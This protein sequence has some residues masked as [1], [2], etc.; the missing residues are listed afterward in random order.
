MGDR[1]VAVR[2][3][4][5]VQGF[6][7][8]LT[9]AAT[10]TEAFGAKLQGA[11]PHV[12]GLV[13]QMATG[14]VGAV[15]LAAAFSAPVKA[16][17][18]FDQ[19]VSRVKSTG[20]VTGAQLE[21]LKTQAM[22]MAGTFGVSGTQAM[23]AVEALAKAGVS[24]SDILGGGLQG[25]L[26][27]AAA[28][29]MDVGQAAETASSAMT[30]FGLSGKDVGHVADVLSNGANMAQ[31][32]VKDL[33]MALSQGG[34]VASQMG[35]SLD[36]TVGALAEFA[37]AGLMGS[38]AGTSLK[39]MLQKLAAPSTQA[40]QVMS[41]LGIHVYDAQ[42]HFVGLDGIAGQLR[43]SM[44]HLSESQRNAAL[45][46]IFGSDAV[47]AASIL[48]KDGANTAADWAKN[49]GK[50][51]AAMQ[52]AT[53][54]QDN[55]AGSLA[56]L[57]ASWTNAF[58]T[59]GES[60]QGPLKS[61]VDK[62][63]AL[64][65]VVQRNAGAAQ[66]IAGVAAALIGLGAAAVG[67]AKVVSAIRAAKTAF[68]AV[69]SAVVTA[70]QSFSALAS[71]AEQSGT[72]TGRALSK[73]GGIKGAAA[74]ATGGV[75]ALGAAM[76]GAQQ[77]VD[78]FALS[79][80]QASAALNGL[81]SGSAQKVAS[82]MDQIN[83]SFKWSADGV[84]DLS[85][86]LKYLNDGSTWHRISDGF[87]Q[88]S[89]GIMGTK[90]NAETL[91]ERF[92]A[93]DEQLAKMRP[94]QRAAAWHQLDAELRRNGTGTSEMI[95][96]MPRLHAMLEEQARSLGVTSLSAKDYADWVGGK[97][98]AAITRAEAA[99]G[100]S[101]KAGQQAANSMKAQVDVAGQL[102]QAYENVTKSL[103]DY[104]SA[105]L[106]LSGSQIGM[107]QG[108]ADATKALKE[109]GRNLDLN[110]EKGRNNQKALN[111]LASSILAYRKNL[112]DQGMGADQAAAKT[113]AAS[114]K[115]I[116]LAQSMGMSAP[117]AQQLAASLGL[118]PDV[119]NAVLDFNIK[120]A[121]PQQIDEL[122]SKIAT[123]PRSQQVQI[124]AIA[125]QKGISEALTYVNDLKANN[126]KTVGIIVT[127]KGGGQKEV[128][129]LNQQIKGLPKD[130]QIKVR[131]IAETK[132]FLPAIDQVNKFKTAAMKDN[133]KPIKH[134]IALLNAG[135]VMGQMNQIE[136][137]RKSID[138]KHI[139]I[140]TSA[141][142]AAAAKSQITS[143]RGAW[144]NINGKRIFV[145]TS[146]PGAV[147]AKAQIDGVYGAWKNINGK[148]VFVPSSAPGATN[149]TGQISSLKSQADAT[150]GKH[151]TVSASADTSAAESALSRLTRT[152]SVVIRAAVGGVSG[153]VAG[154][155]AHANGGIYERHDAQIAKA[156]TYRVWAEPETEGEAYIPFARSKRG[157][158]RAI[159]AQ[160]VQRLGG[161]VQWFANG[162][163]TGA[164]L[165]SVNLTLN[166]PTG[167]IAELNAA[168]R[169][170]TKATRDRQRASRAWWEA[171]RRHAKN[172][173]DL[174]DRLNDA[175]QK[176]ADATKAVSD[177][178][179]TL[180]QNAASAGRSMAS[181]YRAGGSWQDWSAS[182]GQGVKELSA[183]RSDIMRLRSMGLSQQNIDTLTAMGVAGGTEMAR[184]V[185]AGGRNAINA[186]NRNSAALDAIAK[187][188]GLTTIT[189]YAD[190]GHTAQIAYGPRLWAEPE[191]GGE[192]Y[193]PLAA[194]KRERSVDIWWETGRRLGV[195]GYAGGSISPHASRTPDINLGRVVLEVPGLGPAVEA[196]VISVQR[197]T[198]RN[199]AR[200]AR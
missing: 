118:I 41:Q 15:G 106:K 109:N 55:L 74:L 169:A 190:G 138:G 170:A 173:K 60:S 104:A 85:S 144:Q 80:S 7:T 154:L 151:V 93:L 92:G 33:A 133:G 42:G 189:A 181:A 79:A 127:V 18:D 73:V 123:L 121:T 178:I 65:G 125:K 81:A 39:T 102:A 156:G 38:D 63:A 159:A 88:I 82:S 197:S 176:E 184:N 101:G 167:D 16:A 115:F 105:Q 177:V 59:L 112:E 4:A 53:A 165:A 148:R 97:V 30:Q 150:N 36:Q 84:N 142:G 100:K 67:I 70:S 114:Q 24:A 194:S 139:M 77:I 37:N 87:N 2:L 61:I 68:S 145:P 17:A 155:L 96:H 186:L 193:I 110:T 153:A 22:S 187:K 89:N 117:A 1:T 8:G 152:R 11:T 43:Q 23:G 62:L 180:G 78:S 199:L 56:K 126:G 52:T 57:K 49:V 135:S 25:A 20:A 163:I 113:A 195:A 69:K 46:T 174:G 35:M 175:K 124:L 196:K 54:M 27:L 95:E 28:G 12:S 108:M 72:R 91:N 45:A 6:M 192:A 129:K 185:L 83:H 10:A 128:D 198:A 47:R 140:A 44:S 131:T 40:S 71:A 51:G 188:L 58:I 111:D 171:R 14:A 76:Q 179:K 172:T 9:R 141:P 161:A 164:Q 19:A 119:K 200:S 21:Q 147:G 90:S 182:M 157:R 132:G 162:G 130:Q 32:D 107:Y 94:D 149:A 3:K 29:E 103:S 122:R 50:S 158:S 66:G 5:D 99:Q 86:G 120:G 116:E 48:Y 160:A 166:A 31:G 136:N 168:V 134:P 75:V 26:S 98:P 183:F 143:V 146:A 64:A 137:R 34:M 13:G 191:T